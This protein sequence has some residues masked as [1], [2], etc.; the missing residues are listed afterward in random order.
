MHQGV[1]IRFLG[2]AGTVTGSKF[3]LT[4]V[5]DEKKSFTLIDCG[6]F[7]GVKDLRLRNWGAFPENPRLITEV[8]LT[9]AHLDHCGY[10]PMLVKQGFRG[11]IYCT[12]PTKDLAR[13]I[14]LDSA[15]IQEEDADF[16]NR[17]GF[18]KHSPALAL[19][20]SEDVEKALSL[21]KTVEPE[22]W[23]S[24]RTQGLKFRFMPNGHIL[25][26]A[27]IEVECQS[28]KIVFSGDLGRTQPLLFEKGLRLSQANHVVIEATYGDRAH[29]KMDPAEE[30][31]IAVSDVVE[32]GGHLIVPAFAVGRT[33]DLIFLLSELRR[34]NQIPAIPVYLDSP[35]AIRTSEIFTNH[36]SWHRLDESQINQMEELVTLVRTRDES[37]GVMRSKDP[38]VVIAGSGMA[39]GGRVLH[40]LESKLADPKSIVLLTGYQAAGTRGRFLQEGSPTLKF[41]GRYVH[42][43]AQI[44][45]IEG[46][47][48]HADQIELLDW[49]SAFVPSKPAI[50]IV[51]G[52]PH[53]ADALRV[54]IQDQLGLHATVAQDGG[55]VVVG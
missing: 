2:G 6:L 46:L 17:K 30:L 33:Q 9:H 49:L 43:R 1:T 35:M 24:P 23:I 51:H 42:V 28:K 22:E 31:R 52:E 27:S 53:A 32:S 12:K 38:C 10:L 50:S 20:T 18:S 3:L 29:P 21:F 55:E 26:S 7:Q 44:R 5:E 15:K 54:R 25:G 34:K 48:A 45:M 40:H 47:S 36:P 11:R 19:Y 16:A 8:L 37:I 13:V 39:S 14:L 41:H 4:S